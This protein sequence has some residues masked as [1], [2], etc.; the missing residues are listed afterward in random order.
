M[1]PAQSRAQIAGATHGLI[2][3]V[4]RR[5]DHRLLGVN[6][7]GEIAGELIHQGQAAIG[8]GLGI[9]TFIHRTFNIPTFSETYKYAAYDGLPRLE[10][11][12]P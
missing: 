7:A 12:Q 9:D 11:R 2:K 1:V 10:P 4:F 5:D 6:I 3:L 8:C